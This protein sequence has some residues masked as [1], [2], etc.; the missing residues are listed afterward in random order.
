MFIYPCYFLGGFGAVFL[1]HDEKDKELQY[2]LK[3]EK[4]LDTRRHSKLKMEVSYI[5]FIDPLSSTDI[6]VSDCNSQS[7]QRI[8]G[9]IIEG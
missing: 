2:A 1:V 8:Q 5:D 4:K 9:Q 7:C 6:L 3:V